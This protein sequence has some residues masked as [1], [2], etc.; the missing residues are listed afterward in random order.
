MCFVL[1]LVVFTLDRQGAPTQAD[2]QQVQQ[3][4]GSC[5]LVWRTHAHIASGGDRSNDDERYCIS[6]RDDG[7]ANCAF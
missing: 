6:A 3:C 7:A 4:P 5:R 2:Y 1:T